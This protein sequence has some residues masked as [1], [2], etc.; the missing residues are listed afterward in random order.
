[1]AKPPDRRSFNSTPRLIPPINV[2]DL[3]TYP[4]KKRHSKVRISDFAKP[5]RQGG[6]FS[7]FYR[8]LPDILA[9]KTLRAVAGAI[10]KAHRKR[11]PVI[12]V[13]RTVMEGSRCPR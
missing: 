3:K 10:A 5:W 13:Y 8:A 9:V 2:S 1:M 7:L 11:R 4:L 12:R 6:S